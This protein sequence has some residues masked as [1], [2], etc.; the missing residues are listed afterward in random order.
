MNDVNLEQLK[1][2]IKMLDIYDQL[3]IKR[4]EKEPDRIIV[5]KK[6]NHRITFTVDRM[7]D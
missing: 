6:S 1:N 4:D 3:I 2:L 7:M 5:L